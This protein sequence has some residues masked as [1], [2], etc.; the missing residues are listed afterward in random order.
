MSDTDGVKSF[1]YSF[2]NRTYKVVPNYSIVSKPAGGGRLRWLCELRVPGINYVAI[3][4]STIKKDAQTN[5]ARDFVG[6]LIRQKII[7][8]NEASFM[9]SGPELEINKPENQELTTGAGSSVLTGGFQQPSSHGA[10]LVPPI[11]LARQ[12]EAAKPQL[13]MG[14]EK[15]IEAE[16]CDFTSDIH[17]GWTMEN[18]KARLNEYLQSTRQPPINIKYTPVGPPHRLSRV[19]KKLFAREEGSN[20]QTASRA[21][22]L[23]LVRQLFHAGEIEAFTGQRKKK[24]SNEVPSR[25]LQVKVEFLQQM[26]EVLKSHNLHAPPRPPLLEDTDPDSAVG[27]DLIRH[28]RLAKFVGS[29]GQCPAQT[30]P[31]A[32][33]MANW[34]PWTSCNIDEGPESRMTLDQISFKLSSYQR[35]KLDTV[36]VQEM[37]KERRKLPVA[38]YEKELLQTIGNNQITLIRGE[39]GCGKTTQIPQYILDSYLNSGRGAECCVLVTQPRRLCAISLAERVAS[40]RDEEVGKSVGYCVRFETIF[41]R[42]YGSILFCT[43]G[44]IIRKAESGLRGISHIIIDEIHERDVNTDFMLVVIRDMVLANPDLRVV[45][46]SATIDVSLFK[47][48]F[49][50][51]AML[52]LEGR[53]HPVSN[54]YLEDCR[55]LD[56]EPV[57][58]EEGFQN[59]NLLVS[60]EY[61]P[62]VIKTM[63]Q[64]PEKDVPMDLIARLL[65]YILQMNVDGA[66]LI[67]LPGWNIISMLRRF[68][69]QHPRFSNQQQ[70]LILPLHSQVPRDEQRAVFR[71]APY[72]VRKIVLSTNIAE[73]SITINDVVFVIDS[74]LARQK[75]FTARNNMTSYSTC[76]ASKTNLE[77]RRGRAGRV[78]PGYAYHLCSRAR[79]ERLDQHT[80][81][82]MLRT[83]LHEL[84]LLVK[85]LR[86]GSVQDF[87][88]KA[89]QPPPLDAVVEAQFTLRDMMAFDHFDELTPLGYV[90]HSIAH[91]DDVWFIQLYPGAATHGTQTGT[92][93]HLCMHVRDGWSGGHLGCLSLAQSGRVLHLS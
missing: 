57:E 3:G 27:F 35:E 63:S 13:P 82:E 89:L 15:V 41:P 51:C 56:E 88:M 46:M 18:C 80:T 19:Q 70:F 17:G 37:Y 53:M 36:A 85:L 9:K 12:Q 2:V 83:P 32:P 72:G 77:Q 6:Y 50:S 69:R 26:E 61:P 73:S 1:V 91:N 60:Q 8:E 86:L 87:F 71:P 64:M 39:T 92:N 90:S 47:N 24:R 84:A 40:E 75:V 20:K 29:T 38:N 74:C 31:W 76:W 79:Y 22:C 58:V 62:H 14:T 66:I 30:I 43:V 48:Y 34:N 54:F 52:D 67:F 49:G 16:E 44:T 21:V 59:C 5:A 45:L 81:P 93:G 7:N 25:S 11:S 4:N 68:L 42:C 23:S 33:P 10:P 28:E 65:E 78:R 55:K